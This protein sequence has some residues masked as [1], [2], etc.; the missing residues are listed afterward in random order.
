MAA[1]IEKQKE[2]SQYSQL[3]LFTKFKRFW[4]DAKR[5]IAYALIFYLI[6]HYDLPNRFV[7]WVKN[8]KASL[9]ESYYNRWTQKYQP[10]LK[11]PG[12]RA[13]FR[14][15]PASHDCAM[16]QQS[17]DLL[18]KLLYEVDYELQ[19]GFSRELIATVLQHQDM[20][21]QFGDEITPEEQPGELG[22]QLLEKKTA[23]EQ[24][25]AKTKPL[26]N[27]EQRKQML[28]ASGYRTRAKLMSC[29]VNFREFCQIL[30]PYATKF[31]SDATEDRFIS[32]FI[33]L[34]W[35]QINNQDFEKRLREQLQ[36]EENP[37]LAKKIKEE[38]EQAKR[39]E[40]ERIKMEAMSDSERAEYLEQKRL[41]AMPSKWQQTK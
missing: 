39:D 28:E 13:V 35:D 29:S 15:D 22:Q 31:D 11:V 4:L 19:H 21:L 24:A 26:M 30:D 33:R 5:R 36:A 2:Q 17:L 32:E 20:Q 10:D 23:E 25:L 8:K 40:E 18:A 16:R 1:T 9:T 7:R 14:A 3:T 41:A 34:T 27:K 6:Y 12:T 38:K 37:E